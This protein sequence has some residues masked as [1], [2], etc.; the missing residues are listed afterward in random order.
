[1]AKTNAKVKIDKSKGKIYASYNPSTPAAPT[2]VIACQA[3]RLTEQYSFIIFKKEQVI[4]QHNNY[5]VRR[6]IS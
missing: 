1:M 6:A 2:L 4:I 5:R 3:F